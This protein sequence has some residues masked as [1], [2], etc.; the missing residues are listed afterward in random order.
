VADSVPPLTPTALDAYRRAGWHIS[1]FGRPDPGVTT[2]PCGR[3]RKPCH[4]YGPGGRGLCDN[5]EEERRG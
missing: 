2:G 4:L 5:C 1:E 3:C